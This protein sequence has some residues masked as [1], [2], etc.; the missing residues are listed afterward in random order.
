MARIIV[1]A[2][3]PQ[4]YMT[5]VIDDQMPNFESHNEVSLIFYIRIGRDTKEG[6]G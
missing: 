2:S 3:I 4:K 1:L 6:K 5:P